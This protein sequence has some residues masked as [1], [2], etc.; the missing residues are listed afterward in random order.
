VTAQ[1]WATIGAIIAALVGGGVGLRNGTKANRPAES[2]AQLAWVK[3]AQDEAHEAKADAK[4]A[5]VDVAA[6]ETRMRAQDA[7]LD[8][9][10]RRLRQLDATA[11]DLM[12]W[13]E[14]VMRAKDLID[15][16]STNDP[17]VASLLRVI[18]GGPASM[19]NPR[20]RTE[21]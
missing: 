17:A 2:N 20:L 6:A 15:A 10:E 16:Q 3:Q 18:N 4:Q 14:R 5:K 19:S 7:R 11:T 13:I 9:S 8:E 12:Q 1:V 21:P